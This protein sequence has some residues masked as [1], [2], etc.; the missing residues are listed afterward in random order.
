MKVLFFAPHSAIWVHAFPEALVAEA[1]QQSGHEVVYVTCG[2]QFQRF[3]VP[4]SAHRLSPT[5]DDAEKARVCAECDYNK[6][7]LRASFKLPGYDLASVLDDEDR[8]S[9]EALLAQATPQNFLQLVIDGVEVGRAALGTFLLS[10]KKSSFEFTAAEWGAFQIELRNTL[11]SFFAARKIIRR[12]NPDRL[13]VYSSGYSVNLVFCHVAATLGVTFYYM[14]AGSNLTDRLQKLVIAKGHSLQKRLLTYW[15]AFRD[16]PAAAAAMKYATAHFIEVLQGRSAFV[17]STARGGNA[18]DL[19]KY[20]GIAPAQKVLLAALSSYD[21]L[22]A[23]EATGLFPSDY[24]TPFKD[25]VEWITALLAFVRQQPD[26]F[27]IVR[28]HPREFPNKRDALKS[29]HARRLESA[30]SE[31][32]PNARV[33]WPSDNLSLYDI[34][35]ITDAC[36]NSWSSVGKEM[37]LL[38]IPTVIFSPDLVFYPADLNYV[39]E[40]PAEYFAQVER[41]LSSGWSVEHSRMTYRWLAL[42]DRYSRID[43]SDSYRELEH[44]SRT[45][46]ARI[47]RALRRMLGPNYHKRADCR[48]RPRAIAART[49]INQLITE[50]RSSILDILPADTFPTTGVAQETQQL[51]H[52]LHRLMRALYSDPFSAAAHGTLKSRLQNYV[53][54]AS[55]T[56]HTS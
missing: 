29:E 38:G 50:S 51:T 8:S 3:C 22:F 27:L 4:M 40:T 23:A 12:E 17:Y 6:R 56:Q 19:R 16:R 18:V 32:P 20:F 42:E 2:R 43:I 36:L 14:N 37:S 49:L 13:L 25:Q 10:Y 35:E 47:F 24:K 52:E 54:R 34:A 55:R 31:L 9:A 53:R 39:G 44:P 7:L 46:S 26:I 21:E 41:A 15:P 30:L 33:N 28:V 11:Y 5:S 45:W 1:L 48:R